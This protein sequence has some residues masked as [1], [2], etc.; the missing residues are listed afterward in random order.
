V[1]LGIVNPCP[2]ALT[3][4]VEDKSIDPIKTASALSVT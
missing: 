4:T 2:E 1:I 3:V